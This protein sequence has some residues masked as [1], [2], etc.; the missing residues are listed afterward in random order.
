M[1]I[2]L[3]RNKYPKDSLKFVSILQSYTSGKA[4]WSGLRYTRNFQYSNNN[5]K[6]DATIKS[7]TKIIQ[8]ELYRNLGLAAGC[9][10]VVT[11]IL[12]ANIWT[13]LMVFTCV[14][15]TLKMTILTPK[16]WSWW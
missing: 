8:K 14:I 16:L 15:G 1:N 6:I 9:V 3:T 11:L 12:I 2:R 4:G 10:F 5:T 13:S 7:Y